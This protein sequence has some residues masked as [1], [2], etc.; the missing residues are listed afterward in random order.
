MDVP[1]PDE[2]KSR[3]T[4]YENRIY[5][6]RVPLKKLDMD[7]QYLLCIGLLEEIWR[8]VAETSYDA[9]SGTYFGIRQLMEGKLPA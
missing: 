4:D 2:T 8:W 7:K 9:P 6:A 5:T 3:I 1:I